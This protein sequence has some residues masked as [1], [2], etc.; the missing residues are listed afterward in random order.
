MIGMRNRYKVFSIVEKYREI[1][2]GYSSFVDTIFRDTTK[3][4]RINRLRT[5][6]DYIRSRLEEFDIEIRELPWY[7]DAFL[8]LNGREKIAKTLDY[9][10]GL[11]YIMEVTSLI[12]PL[13][14]EKYLGDINLDIAAAPGGKAL[15]IAEMLRDKGIV[16]G[17]D[18][19]PS[20]YKALVSN[21][22]RMGYSNILVTRIDGRRYPVIE[23]LK[24]VLFDAPCSSEI[25][26]SRI[27]DTREYLEG[28]IYKKY[29]SLQISILKRLFRI[30]P[31]NSI[32]LYSV[33]TFSPLESEYVVMKA[34]EMGFK[35]EDI[36]RL[37]LNALN[38][39]ESWNG[40]T[41]PEEVKYTYRIYPHI[42]ADYGNPGYLYVALLR[43]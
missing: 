11:Y 29:S 31:P 43:R 37:P 25:H 5:T 1:I 9:H 16:I 15:M 14:I 35:V 10:L 13:I 2:P 22:D 26:V 36:P 38:G 33:C 6:S 42:N 41:F 8:V 17:N 18:P 34:I 20:R 23:G 3:V 30:L 39:V 27:K 24:T 4:I 21:I 28:R 40:I 32:V 7:K 19:D 12:P